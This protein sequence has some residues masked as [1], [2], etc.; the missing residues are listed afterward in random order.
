MSTIT[1]I[2][3]ADLHTNPAFSQGVLCEAGPTL[4]IGG[5]NG[6]D[7]TGA[8]VAG[9]MAEQTTKALQNVMSVLAAA[10][11]K[12]EHVVKMTIYLAADADLDAGVAAT[13]AT[14]GRHPTAISVIRVAAIARPDALVEIDAVARVP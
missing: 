10:G 8:I 2:N 7:A 11:A 3:P 1:H 5:Q 9:G 4:Y 13:A 12:P 6:T 14:W